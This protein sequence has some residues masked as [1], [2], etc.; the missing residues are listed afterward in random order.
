MSGVSLGHARFSKPRAPYASDGAY[1]NF[2][3]EEESDRVAAAYGANI[4]GWHRSNSVTIRDNSF[5]IWNQNIKP[6]G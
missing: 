6:R 2:M 1:V 5:S 3:T 4:I